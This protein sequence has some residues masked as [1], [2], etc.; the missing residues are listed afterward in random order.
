MSC[1]F[2]IT[3]QRLAPKLWLCFNHHRFDVQIFCWNGAQQAKIHWVECG[4]LRQFSSFQ[5]CSLLFLSLSAF[6]TH[7]HSFS[8]VLCFYVLLILLVQHF[9][10]DL[11]SI[12][13]VQLLST[14][15]PIVGFIHVHD[16]I[17]SQRLPQIPINCV[18]L[19]DVRSWHRRS[20]LCGASRLL[21]S[22]RLR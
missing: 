11:N 7:T 15:Y 20:R 22:D 3:L 5:K 14:K 19:F 16:E 6:H 13:S 4:T 17:K 1:L 18:S 2:L 12:N 21:F 8:F 9:H 10:F